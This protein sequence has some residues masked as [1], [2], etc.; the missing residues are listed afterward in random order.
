[1][2]APARLALARSLAARIHALAAGGDELDVL[3]GFL[4][5]LELG[6]SRY[7]A[8]DLRSDARDW[9][10]EQDE[11]VADWA[12]YRALARTSR[13]YAQVDALHAGL[14]ELAQV[15]GEGEG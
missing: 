1:M 3:D 12:V 4:L 2:T 10:R 5:R 7:G 8:L 9:Q 14:G 6:R 13:R 11:E 15:E